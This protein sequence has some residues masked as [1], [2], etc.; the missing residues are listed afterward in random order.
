[1]SDIKPKGLKG[2]KITQ[3]QGAE[4]IYKYFSER[5]TTVNVTENNRNANI[6]TFSYTVSFEEE[7]VHVAYM[8]LT[9]VGG[10]IYYYLMYRDIGGQTLVPKKQERDFLAR[11][12][13]VDMEPSYHIIEDNLATIN[14]V[15]VKT[16]SS[17]IRHD[18]G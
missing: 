15:Y 12:G 18:E 10:M 11:L 3:E 7:D 2:D 16:E 14:F 1:M 5:K 9:E 17:T 8:D 4:K 13:V 6:K